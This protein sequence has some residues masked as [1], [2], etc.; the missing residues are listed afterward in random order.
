MP[1]VISRLNYTNCPPVL[2]HTWAC[3]RT[4]RDHSVLGFHVQ[5]DAEWYLFKIQYRR[6]TFLLPL[7][8][9]SPHPKQLPK[10]FSPLVEVEVQSEVDQS[11]HMYE[12]DC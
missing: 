6:R 12:I 11:G 10:C 1:G 3:R 2:N 4:R 8:C 7:L 5:L 9:S